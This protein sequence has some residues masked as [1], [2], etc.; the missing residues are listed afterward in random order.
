EIL[1]CA[2]RRMD[3]VMAALAAADG[4]RTADVVGRCTQCV[5]LA[6][7][8][9]SADGMDRGQVNNVKAHLLERRQLSDDIEQRT[10]AIVGIPRR[11]REQFVPG[12]KKGLWAFNVQ[13]KSRLAAAGKVALLRFV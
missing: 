5:V 9:G 12:G 10:M 3:R 2:K 4:I 11:T 13:G 7:A 8:V 6:F 1:D